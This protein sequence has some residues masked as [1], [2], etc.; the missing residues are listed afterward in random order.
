MVYPYV[1]LKASILSILAWPGLVQQC[2]RCHPP[3]SDAGTHL[4]AHIF[5]QNTWTALLSRFIWLTSSALLSA[6]G[7]GRLV[8][9]AAALPNSSRILR[10]V[11]VHGRKM[12]MFLSL[13]VVCV[14]FSRQFCY[15][16]QY[17][18]LF[19]VWLWSQISLIL[20]RQSGGVLGSSFQCPSGLAPNL[21]PVCCE[22]LSGG[23]LPELQ[24]CYKTHYYTSAQVC[25]LHMSFICCMIYSY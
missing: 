1:L 17:F 15:L 6:E 20:Q 11:W 22:N 25:L 12:C 4:L 21:C 23:S 16:C 10:P 14:C 24:P 5:D 13:C 9:C 18:L 7:Q 2:Q 3:G 19:R 8:F